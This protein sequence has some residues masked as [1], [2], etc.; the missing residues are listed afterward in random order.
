MTTHEY[1]YSWMM[2][3]IYVSKNTAF[4]LDK[5]ITATKFSKLYQ[6]NYCIKVVPLHHFLLF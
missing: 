4:L 3:C 5:N 6:K 2:A 1:T